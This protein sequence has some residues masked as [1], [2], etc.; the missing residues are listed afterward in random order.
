MLW[1]LIKI[2]VFVAV[3]AAAVY[4]ITLVA[5]S[6]E[7]LTVLF[8]GYE[9]TL[10]PIQALIAVLLLFVAVWIV[11]RIVGLVVALLRFIAGDKTA[12]TRWF[13]RHREKRGNQLLTEGM[14]ALAS[15]DS[16]LAL[17]KAR[18]ADG[19]LPHDEVAVLLAAQA[20]EQMGD[21]TLAVDSYKKLLSSDRTRFV[22]I[23]GLMRQKQAEGDERTARKLAE[24]AL[25]LKPDH[26]EVA[27][28]LFLMQ[29]HER[30][31]AAARSTMG[32]KRRHKSAPK[33]L[34][35]RRDGL[36][37]L[38]QSWDLRRE[39]KLE[40][41]RKAAL[42]A[43]KELPNFAPA[44]VEAA[45]AQ[46][47]AGSAVKAAQLIRTAWAAEPHPSL[48]AAYAAID[49]AETPQKRLKRFGDLV[50]KD[51]SHPEARMLMAELN[52]AAEDFPQARRTLGDLVETAPTARVMTLMAAVERGEG[53]TDTA[54]KAWLAKAVT[55]P[56][57][58][59]WVC[60]VEGA[61]Y[62]E[63]QPVCDVCGSFDTLAWRPAPASEAMP[64]VSAGMLP[65][66]VGALEDQS[67]DPSAEEA[68]TVE[69]TAEESTVKA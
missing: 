16:R 62:A 48:A 56:R 34:A 68:A 52:I 41:A 49:P 36:L 21:R 64:E 59:A 10:G 27:D 60:E 11:L 44:V 61:V 32:L 29:T 55:A 47:E 24:T 26:S 31:W 9:I 38:C 8:A 45:K 69:A 6:G 17:R 67:A 39:G 40:E 58:N 1:T 54:V 51:P 5:A 53:G 28:Q 30:D 20:A 35:R 66:I 25:K 46:L 12:F 4:G 50:R 7:T 2:L 65:L 57:G 33:D 13:Y 15:G 37:A 42:E 22:A 23:R 3:V 14:L 19:K 18:A 43:A 63:W